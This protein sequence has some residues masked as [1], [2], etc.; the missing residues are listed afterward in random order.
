[1]GIGTG[2][3]TFV[4]NGSGQPHGD[5]PSGDVEHGQV[6]ESLG[7]ERQ[8]NTVGSEHPAPTAAEL[9]AHNPVVNPG[10]KNRQPVSGSRPVR[11]K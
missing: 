2:L 1:M 4:L 5:L 10:G 3:N 7:F 9:A 11:S 8:D 6:A